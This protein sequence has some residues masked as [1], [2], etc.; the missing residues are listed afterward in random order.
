MQLS[1]RLE[2]PPPPHHGVW[3][4]RLKSVQFPAAFAGPLDATQRTA[5]MKKVS[6]SISLRMRANPI[7]SNE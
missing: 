4:G 2:H 5:A 6:P 7:G 1:N 3:P